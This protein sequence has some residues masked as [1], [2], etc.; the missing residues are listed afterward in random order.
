MKIAVFTAT[1]AEYGILSGLLK[2]LQRD[3]FFQLHLIVSGSHLSPEFGLTYRDIEADG[4]DISDKVEILLSSNTS[5]GCAKSVGLA[6]IS[7]TDSLARL[8]PDCLLVLGDR[9]ELLAAAQ[10]ALLLNIPIVHIHGGEI[11]QGAIDDVV[12]HCVSKMAQLHFVA[13]EQYRQRVIQLGEQ[14]SSVINCGALGIDNIVNFP[15]ISRASLA[16]QL[17]LS[18]ERPFCLLT[19]HSVTAVNEDAIDTFNAIVDACLAKCNLDV[20]ITYPNADHGGRDIIACIDKIKKSDSNRI[21]VFKSLGFAR[22]I[23]TIREAKFVIGN[24]SSGV[25]EVPSV[26]VPAINVGARQLGRIAAQSVIHCGTT[27]QDIS[28]A[29]DL[30]LTDEQQQIAKHVT[31]PYGKGNSADTIISCLKN[32]EFSS[33][34]KVFYDVSFSE[35]E[36]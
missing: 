14:P 23:S 5:V 16:Q 4:F 1:R 17:Q 33:Q 36:H 22:Y 19:Y 2:K 20:I 32:V 31:N 30:A 21:S 24:S 11:T 13:T 29:I 6:M 25:I 9:T 27:K 8:Q 26:G 3:K 28:D 12:R 7:L 10:S 35:R 34:G 18:L 15:R